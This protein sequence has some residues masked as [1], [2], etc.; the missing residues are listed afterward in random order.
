MGVFL[1]VI[2]GRP[3][4]PS[5][6]SITTAEEYGFRARVC[7]APRNDGVEVDARP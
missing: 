4:R 1:S 2:P 5:P 7:V 6:E 3:E